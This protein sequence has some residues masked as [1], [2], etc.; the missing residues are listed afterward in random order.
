M[1]GENKILIPEPEAGRSLHVTMRADQVY[2]LGFSPETS[3]FEHIGQDVRVEFE[4]GA[5]ITLHAF[6]SVAE[7]KDFIL[8]LRDGTQISGRDMAEALAFSLKDF[9]TD[10]APLAMSGG[11]P[12]TTGIAAQDPVFQAEAGKREGRT[13]RLEDV[14]DAGPP[15]LF[16]EAPP[17]CRPGEMFSASSA[18]PSEADAASSPGQGAP[19]E[20][21]D[22]TL[23]ALLRIDM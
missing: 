9:H 8:E 11:C 23:L 20:D 10:G 7:Q 16:A 1:P 13:L 6:F 2:L 3:T 17:A 5:D 12:F 18:A 19:G 14:L 15:A 22:S 21:V 4:N